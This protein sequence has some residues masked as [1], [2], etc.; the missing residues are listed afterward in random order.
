MC[1]FLAKTI[2]KYIRVVILKAKQLRAVVCRLQIS[3]VLYS[4]ITPY[5][6]ATNARLNHVA[7]FDKYGAWSTLNME[8]GQWI[9]V[10]LG[11][12]TKVT[13][14]GTRGRSDES[15]WVT[16]YKVSYS[17]DGGYFEFYKHD[18]YGDAQV[19][20]KEKRLT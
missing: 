13:K 5:Q 7:G 9:Q 18:P 16:K 6:G 17:F 8:Q 14:I 11:E 10:D 15:E 20:S 3:G 1:Y 12:I 2:E 19:S 4:Q